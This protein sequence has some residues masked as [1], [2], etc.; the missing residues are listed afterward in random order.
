MNL[1]E[2]KRQNLIKEVEPDFKQIYMQAKRAEKD[3]EAAEKISDSDKT[4]AYTIAYHAMIRISRALMYSNG[5]LPTNKNTHKTIIEY[6]GP[7]LGKEYSDLVAMF[8]R[9]RR[10]RHEFIYESKNGIS[11]DRVKMSI[12]N[13]KK[14][15]NE[16]VKILK[17]K[18]PQFRLPEI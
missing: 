9:M 15:I 14:L 4:W 18:D 5:Y 11:A 6:V 8:S 17:K 7:V 1:D 12:S 16:I 10:E 3:V 13:A 2:Y